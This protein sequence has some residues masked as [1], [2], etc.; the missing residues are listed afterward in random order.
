MEIQSSDWSIDRLDVSDW[1][2][3]ATHLVIVPTFDDLLRDAV[4]SRQVQRAN[5]HGDR[6]LH[7]S[8]GQSPDIL[9]AGGA[10]H[11]GLAVRSDVKL[12]F[13]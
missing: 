1:S 11:Y 9:W 5:E 2:L 12:M 6:I 13:C 3:V 10:C 7:V 8:L 4:D